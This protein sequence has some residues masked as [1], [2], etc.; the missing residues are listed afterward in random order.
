[1][2]TLRI[3]GPHA[4]LSN[5]PPGNAFSDDASPI[6]IRRQIGREAGVSIVSRLFACDVLA[7]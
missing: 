6:S 1:M 5:H 3:P 7:H 2:A 4:S